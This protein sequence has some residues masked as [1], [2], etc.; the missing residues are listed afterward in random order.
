MSQLLNATAAG[1]RVFATQVVNLTTG[2]LPLISVFTPDESA[3]APNEQELSPREYQ[4]RMDVIIEARAEQTDPAIPIDRVLDDLALEIETAMHSDIFLGDP[5]GKLVDDVVMLGTAM[6]PD[7]Q[8]EQIRGTVQLTYRVGY[9]TAGY[10][11]GV[12]PPFEEMEITHDLAGAQPPA[13]RAVDE[14]EL[15]QP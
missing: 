2:Q 11:E 5:D 15:E 10:V 9:T 7:D 8:G 12:I 6:A 4:R 14:F 3:E 13:D 1:D